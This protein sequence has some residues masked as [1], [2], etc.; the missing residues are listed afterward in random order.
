MPALTIDLIASLDG[1]GSAQGWPGYWG[2]EG[3]EYLRWLDEQEEH[4]ALLGATTYR[5]MA[6]L[7]QEAPDE[8]AGMTAQ[9][10]V[11]F[12]STLAEPLTWANTELVAGDAVEAVRAMKRD[13]PRPLRTVGSFA[14]GRALLRGGLVDRLRIVVFPVVTGVSGAGRVLEGWPDVTLDMVESRT[15]DGRLQL[16]EY[17]PTV[18][19]GPPGGDRSST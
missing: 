2:R 7:V 14:L 19:D 6:Q 4:T 15:F 13:H 11:V 8:A 18:L 12:S 10:K 3:P 5:L 17:A 1:Y 16:L 9:P